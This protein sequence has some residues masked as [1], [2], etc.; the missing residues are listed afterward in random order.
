MKLFFREPQGQ[1]DVMNIGQLIRRYR[2]KQKLT[3]K[4]VAEKAGISESFLSQVENNV[5]SPLNQAEN[6]ESLIMVRRPDWGD[7]EIP[8]AGFATRRFFSPKNR[9]TID[10]AI[11]AV[12][13][14]KSIP[15]RKNVRNGQEVL[16]VLK[17]S[18]E[19]VHG[20]RTERMKAGDT[21]H[22]WAE[23]KRQRITNNGKGIAYVLWVGTL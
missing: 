1:Y 2:K 18:L 16:C 12:A 19:L 6:Q 10:S 14:G 5:N 4:A 20:E 17:G 3:L 8:S 9:V 7:I 13:P 21:V 23:P 15:V 22:Y 11:L